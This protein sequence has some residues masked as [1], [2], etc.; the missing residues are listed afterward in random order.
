MSKYYEITIIKD[1]YNGSYSHGKWTAWPM[2]VYDIPWAQDAGDSDCANFW[3]QY[4][5]PVGKG[6]TPDGA[7]NNLEE[8][9]KPEVIK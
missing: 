9:L 5:D 8:Q 3:G 6:D 7:L 2:S 4:S 1:R